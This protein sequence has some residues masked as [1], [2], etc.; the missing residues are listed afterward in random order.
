MQYVSTHTMGDTEQEH[1]FAAAQG[2]QQ[3]YTAFRFIML[4]TYASEWR[5]EMTI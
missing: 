5:T 4:C 1:V 3:I 2:E